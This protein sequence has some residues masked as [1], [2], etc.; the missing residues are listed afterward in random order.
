MS[1]D[2]STVRRLPRW[3]PVIGAMLALVG[4]GIARS[5]PI[6]IIAGI[7]PLMYLG[8]SYWETNRE[9]TFEVT[10]TIENA[11]PI[12]GETVEIQL[13]ITNTGTSRIPD[14]RCTDL[15]PN[16]LEV[17]D[18]ATRGGFS[19]RSG[20]RASVQYSVLAARGEHEF[21]APIIRIRDLSGS[22]LRRETV[23]T[24]QS[25]ITCKSHI[26]DVPT[27]AIA[28]QNTGQIKSDSGSEG[29]EF[30]ATRDYHSG[31]PLNRILWRHLAKTGDLATIEFT[32][33]RATDVFI[34]VDSRQ[35]NQVTSQ[36]NGMSAL[37]LCTYA[38]ERCLES[39]LMDGTTVGFGSITGRV[40]DWH[41]PNTGIETIQRA[42]QFFDQ[43][44]RTPSQSSN[45]TLNGIRI[46]EQINQFVS[47]HTQIL[48]LSPLLDDDPIS[49][50]KAVREQTHPV[51]VLSPD[52]TSKA[53]P[54]ERIARLERSV[55]LDRIRSSNIRVIDWDPADPLSIA[56]EN[57]H[58]RWKK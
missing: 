33:E 51:T 15:V 44:A 30:F 57:D 8:F 3:S 46:A 21:S 41:E 5:T 7:I 17:K 22:W 47:T 24:Q 11:Q 18:G 26:S 14:I 53:S 39:L 36:Y 16:Q 29:I 42:N 32:E 56:L 23:P 27:H 45:R 55:R 12:P 4:A 6:L 50:V 10:R 13:S 43:E 28:S 20:E 25:T 40:E 9:S 54:G 2:V 52:A 38:G 34:V 58:E 35:I 31:D 48:L 37:S 1:E 49:V 19:L